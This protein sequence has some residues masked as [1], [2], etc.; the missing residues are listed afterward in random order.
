MTRWLEVRRHSLTKKG[1]N[2]GRGSH[3][4][5]EG[6]ELAREVG[7]RT[8]PFAFVITGELPRHLE[9]ALAMGYAVD[10]SVRLPSGY[11]PGEVEYHEQW[12]WDQPYVRY[13]ELLDRKRRLSE[14]AD[15]HRET[16][17]HALESISDSETAL[18]ICSGGAIEPTLVACLPEADHSGWGK[19]FGH[20]DG[21]RLAF[22]DGKFMGVSFDRARPAEDQ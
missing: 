7:S 12:T 10:G 17:L 5:Q 4:S 19:P 13:R 15:A 14:V 1:P 21:A 2:R 20:C 6:V 11:I 8:G 3:L 9:T 22:E 18:V 16:W